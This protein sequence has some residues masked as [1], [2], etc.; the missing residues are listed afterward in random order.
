M[1]SWLVDQFSAPPLPSFS[2]GG[3]R[4]NR[5]SVVNGDKAYWRAVDKGAIDGIMV[6]NPSEVLDA[7]REFECDAL[8][9]K[10]L[11]V[12]NRLRELSSSTN[13]SSP[14]SGVLL[15]NYGAALH[16]YVPIGTSAKP[17]FAVGVDTALLKILTPL[18]MD[19]VLAYHLADLELEKLADVPMAGVP[20][21]VAP[22]L[23]L[24]KRAIEI[25]TN[26]EAY[27]SRL[28]KVHQFT[29]EVVHPTAGS[30][31]VVTLETLAH[32]IS[33]PV[34]LIG[35]LADIIY[36]QGAAE[37]THVARVK[38]A[39]GFVKRIAEGAYEATRHGT[40]RL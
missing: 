8:F 38:Q 13:L 30:R 20:K 26:A 4:F 29:Q 18:E 5:Q 10:H 19:S 31:A 3:A 21:N 36:P 12:A 14:V 15:T 16:G 35:R 28:E 2:V 24:D 32:R 33:R 22:L 6:R 25:T 37:M 34:P 11:T 9:K 7:L 27:L 40:I 23:A 17:K 39:E 1:L